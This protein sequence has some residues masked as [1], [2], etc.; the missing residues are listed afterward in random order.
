M[1]EQLRIDLSICNEDSGWR[2]FVPLLHEARVGIFLGLVFLCFSTVALVRASMLLGQ[3]CVDMS[4][5]HFAQGGTSLV[6]AFIGFE[7]LS[8][9]SQYLGRRN[10]AQA[11]NV[12]LLNLRRA[13][14]NKLSELPMSYFDS[15][16]LGRVIT[17]LTNDVDGMEG[18]FGS[19]LARMATAIVQMVIVLISIVSLKPG[20]GSMVVLAAVPS[21]AFSMLTRRRL[22]FWLQENKSR[23]AHVNSTL[24]EFIQGLPVLRVMGLEKWSN[25]EFGKDTDSHFESSIRVLSWNSFIRPVTVFLSVMPTMTAALIG[26]WMLSKGHIELA[27]IVAVLRL[28]ERFS[29][30]VRVL[31]QEIQMIQDASTSAMRVAEMLNSESEQLNTDIGGRCK[32]RGDIE[33]QNV[34]LAYRSGK[35]ILSGVSLTIPAGQKVGILGHSGA[36][37]SSMVNLIP[38]LYLPTTGSVSIDGVKLSDWDLAALR[39]QIGYLSQE[40]FLFKGSLASNILGAERALDPGVRAKFTGLMVELGLGGILSRFPGGLD[41]AVREAGANLSGGERQMVAFLRAASDQRPILLMDEATSC[42]DREWEDAIQLAILALLRKQKRTCVI[43][44]HRLET[45]RSC[46]RLIRLHGG[47]IVSDE[48]IN[49]Q[50]FL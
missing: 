36:G 40:P 50:S 25:E 26:G 1:S 7:I 22:R 39:S 5:G 45:L 9:C 43:I 2:G 8:V 12:T 11:T 34:S 46:D 28:T 41:F 23:N 35:S 13:L 15:Q 16:P 17:R 37:K 32:I 33:F 49:R 20:Y 42:L 27:A 24:A 10:L 44:A 30:P 31:T 14:F 21:L 6:T 19:S 3:I 29:N 38:A 4:S 18:F 47:R 48:L